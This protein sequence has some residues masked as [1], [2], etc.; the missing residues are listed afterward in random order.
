MR[1]SVGE[2]LSKL[3]VW[4]VP[5]IKDYVSKNISWRCMARRLRRISALDVNA[6]PM[7]GIT[8]IGNFDRHNGNWG[9]LVDSVTRKAEIAPAYDFGS[10]LLPQADDDIMSRVIEDKAERDARIYTFPA[11]ALKQNGKKIG[12]IDFVAQNRS[13]VLSSALNRIVPRI[14]LAAINAFIDDTPLLTALQRQFYK[15]YLSARYE[16]VF[17]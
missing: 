6:L 12:Y 11:S 3:R 7:R 10:C 14:D 13:G 1:S 5:G 16:A 9:F 8:L 4:G 17:G 15:T 2:V